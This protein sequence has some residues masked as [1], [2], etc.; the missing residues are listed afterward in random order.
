MI[1]QHVWVTLASIIGHQEHSTY[2]FMKLNFAYDNVISVSQS[3]F[4]L[5]CI[6]H[7]FYRLLDNVSLTVSHA[8]SD[9]LA[10]YLSLNNA[11]GRCYTLENTQNNT[12][13]PNVQNLSTWYGYLNSCC[14]NVSNI[15]SNLN[16]SVANV[17]SNV[18]TLNT[19][20][21]YVS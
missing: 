5:S 21:V 16:S 13:I 12:L 20:I 10:I 14:M 11:S 4:N 2:C 1:Y 6:V 15:C 8:S 19:T 3:V 9:V 18:A 7:A 17:S